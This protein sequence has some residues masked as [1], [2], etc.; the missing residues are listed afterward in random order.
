M[1]TVVEKIEKGIDLLLKVSKGLYIVAG[2]LFA[3][4]YIVCALFKRGC[5]YIDPEFPI[6]LKELFAIFF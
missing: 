6:H 2:L 3:T 4:L 5:T 1:N